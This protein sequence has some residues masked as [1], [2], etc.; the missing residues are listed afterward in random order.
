[1]KQGVRYIFAVVALYVLLPVAGVE[2][3]PFRLP[4]TAKVTKRD[5]KG[6]TWRE[7]GYVN[8]PFASAKGQFAC[9][10]SRDGWRI[11]H[12]ISLAH[13]NGRTLSAWQR[14]QQEIVLMLWREGA[15]KTG[16]SW[17]IS[18]RQKNKSRRRSK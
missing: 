2:K 8:A 15:S 4:I 6:D 11:V 10:L 13:P 1:M 12:D 9:M 14:G 18:D 17:G 5:A 3:P 7:N 16:F